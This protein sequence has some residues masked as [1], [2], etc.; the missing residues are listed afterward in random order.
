MIR[1]VG[2]FATLLA[3]CASAPCLAQSPP[4]E[5]EPGDTI[6][7]TGKAAP[8]TRGALA[9]QAQ[10][11]SRIAPNKLYV[12]ALPRFE[13]PICPRVLGLDDDY[14]A[15]I[16]RRIRRNL[17]RLNL[18]AAKK[19]C[20]SNLLVLFV[21]DGRGFLA[22][23]VKRHEPTFQWVA[24]NERAELLDEQDP[25]RVWSVIQKRWTG[26]G[27]PPDGWPDERPSVWG[28]LDRT[29]MPEANDI[30]CAFVI[31]E[32]DRTVGLTLTQVADYATMRGLTHTRPASGEASMSTILSLFEDINK[33]PPELTA[34]DIGYLRSLYAGEANRSAV[35]KFL[36]IRRQTSLA[37]KGSQPSPEK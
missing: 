23:L 3:A 22:D 13:A 15:G 32:R 37:R 10:D 19:D 29:S 20:I 28:Q 16:T 17:A 30:A 6:V 34:F 33:R 2:H 1:R 26:N 5:K 21:D 35:N 25:V 14:A 12:E 24:A 11:I 31:F 8:P 7:I 4:P 36:G 27:Q 18:P 9:E